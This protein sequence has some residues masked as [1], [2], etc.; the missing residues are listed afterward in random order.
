MRAVRGSSGLHQFRDGTHKV[1]PDLAGQFP[2][3]GVDAVG[4]EVPAGTFDIACEQREHVRIVGGI[5][6]L[7]KVDQDD[8]ALSVEDII[9]RQVAMNA[10]LDQ[11]QL[12]VAHDAVKERVCFLLWKF[13]LAEAGG[14]LVDGTNIFH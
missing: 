6:R 3:V 9:C 8:S 13:D 5:D 2:G 12:D 14:R 7:G 4:C 1:G 11:G 10:T